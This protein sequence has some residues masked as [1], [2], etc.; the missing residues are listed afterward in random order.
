M[1]R[2]FVG[3]VLFSLSISCNQAKFGAGDKSKNDNDDLNPATQELIVTTPSD[4]IKAGKKTMQA[5][6]T[7][8]GQTEKPDVI[9]TLSSEVDDKGAIDEQGLYT[10]PD[11][12]D[13]EFPVTL[14]ATLKSNPNVKG[15]KTITVI[16]EEQIFATCTEGSQNFPIVAK[17][18]QMNPN[19][20]QLPDYNNPS[21]ATYK[22]KVCME[23]YAVEPRRFEEG[24]PKV[25]ELFE[26]FS[27]QTT[28]TLFA[29]EDGTYIFEL[30]SDD[31][32]R[33]YID[34][35]EVINND[36]EHQAYSPDPEDSQ[37]EGLK[38]V[39]IHLT[40]GDHA[41]ALNYFQGP[42]FRIGLML[43]WKLPSSNDLV[44]VPR[45]NFK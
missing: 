42:R 38:Q 4:T 43:K 35:A 17:V 14:I 20:K 2:L 28:T 31:G 12:A 44:Y 24:F 8:K 13:K 39:V 45:E 26:Y 11:K 18:Y 41:L 29:P 37:T 34:G 15:Q 6:A 1:K 9:W 7:L 10:S 25:A 23:N 30:N 33:L 5:T 16:P 3:L 19:V 32:S 40:K 36:G 22:T 21:E 27:L